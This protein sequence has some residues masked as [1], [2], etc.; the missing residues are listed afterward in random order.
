VS[1]TITIEPIGR[2]GKYPVFAAKIGSL[3]SSCVL[4]KRKR[5]FAEGDAIEYCNERDLDGMS[6]SCTPKWERGTVWKVDGDRLFIS[7]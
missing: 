7:R 6:K 3:G 2:W 5:S 4:V 1:E